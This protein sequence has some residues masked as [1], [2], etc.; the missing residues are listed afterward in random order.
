MSFCLSSSSSP[1]ASPPSSIG[2]PLTYCSKSSIEAGSA[3]ITGIGNSGS[4]LRISKSV[5]IS[6]NG[7]PLR[8]HVMPSFLTVASFLPLTFS[9]EAT[10][11][12]TTWVRVT[13]SSYFCFLVL[14]P[15]IG[16]PL[17]FGEI[18]PSDSDWGALPLHRSVL[19]FF[20]PPTFFPWTVSSEAAITSAT[21]ARVTTSSY[22]C[23]LVRRLPLSTPL[24]SWEVST[25]DSDWE[26]PFLHCSIRRSSSQVG[27]RL[28][29][30]RVCLPSLPSR[31]VSSTHVW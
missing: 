13:A 31:I 16:A 10:F 4:F 15:S 2:S 29:I 8:F 30:R 24:P 19:W 7:L 9:A 22:F 5:R 6:S 1:T 23:P 26:V 11:T 27:C 17:P 12:S 18:S 28:L 20:F 3:S 14:C 21:W 25:S